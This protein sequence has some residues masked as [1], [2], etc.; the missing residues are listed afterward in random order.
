M[1]LAKKRSRKEKKKEEDDKIEMHH[2]PDAGSQ[3]AAAPNH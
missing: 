2:L 1:A 3:N